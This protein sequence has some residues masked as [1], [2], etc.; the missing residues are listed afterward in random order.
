MISS[1]ARVVRPPMF[2]Q[3][4]MSVV[5]ASLVL[6]GLLGMHTLSVSHSE[7]SPVAATSMEGG[8][9]HD[10]LAGSSGSLDVGCA[11]CGATGEH[12]ALMLA[13]VLGL[14]VTILLAVRAGPRVIRSFGRPRIVAIALRS[15]IL[16]PSRPPSLLELSISRT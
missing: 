9:G 5:F 4:A 12:D 8:H 13:C 6:V 16:T 1:A 11:D 7:S 3:W 15:P 10:A 2:W 14:L